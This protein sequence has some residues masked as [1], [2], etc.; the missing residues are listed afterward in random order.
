M[1]HG[2]NKIK[3]TSWSEIFQAWQESEGS[4]T[5]WQE[6]AKAKGFDFWEEWRDN[7]ANLIG[8]KD[9][10]WQLFEISE[11]NLI[12]PNFRLGP[13][14][15]WQE[16][17]ENKFQHTFLDLAKTNLDWLKKRIKFLSFIS[18]WVC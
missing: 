12:I 16:H 9:K 15:G 13:F 4:L 14:Q 17:F 6:L 3:D 18:I 10:D 7:T 11:P 1:I 8:A 5:S 2:L